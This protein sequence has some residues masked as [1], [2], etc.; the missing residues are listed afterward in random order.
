VPHK[1]RQEAQ[2]IANVF[3]HTK[4]DPNTVAIR[5]DKT[6]KVHPD[7]SDVA[8]ILAALRLFQREYEGREAVCIADEWPMHFN[9]QAFDSEEINVVPM[10][11]GSEDIDEL[12]ERINCAR[13]LHIVGGE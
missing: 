7:S 5:H 11:L 4:R 10:P 6:E 1:T 2:L 12:C 3:N 9:V 13:T 8:T